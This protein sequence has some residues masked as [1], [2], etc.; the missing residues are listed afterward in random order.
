MK[1][2]LALVALTLTLPGC[3]GSLEQ[4]R[5]AP[6][7]SSTGPLLAASSD[8]SRDDARC[9]ELDD[10]RTFWGAVSV[11]ATALGGGAG[12][13]TIPVENRDLQIGLASGVVVSAAVAATAMYIER[14]STESWTQECAQ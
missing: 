5:S 11:G 3:A 12:L 8:Q 2:L 1:N 14:S 9:T 6:H 7:P 4:A 13:S 10:R